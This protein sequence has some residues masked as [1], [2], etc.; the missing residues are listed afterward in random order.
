MYVQQNLTNGEMLKYFLC[1]LNYGLEFLVCFSSG[2]QI[3]EYG[4]I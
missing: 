3:A 2:K 1:M 4:I